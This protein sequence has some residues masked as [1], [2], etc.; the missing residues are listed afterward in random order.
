MIEALKTSSC[1]RVKSVETGGGCGERGWGGGGGGLGWLVAERPDS[2]SVYLRYVSVE[3]V[4]G[5]ATLA[6]K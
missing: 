4:V 6:Y 2:M 5:V 1:I 3:T